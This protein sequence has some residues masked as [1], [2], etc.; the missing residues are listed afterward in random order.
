MLNPMAGITD[1]YRTIILS[2]ESPQAE[3]LLMAGAVSVIL[4]LGSY[5]YFKNAETEFADII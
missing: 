4:F 2:A 1:A 5:W 3:Y